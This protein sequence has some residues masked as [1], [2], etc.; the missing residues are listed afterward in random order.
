MVGGGGVNRGSGLGE[1]MGMAFARA[2][3]FSRA[4]GCPLPP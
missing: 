3:T 2:A 4:S 1:N